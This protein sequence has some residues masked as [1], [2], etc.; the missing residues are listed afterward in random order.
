[1][2]LKKCAEDACMRS[3]RALPPALRF[4]HGDMS[5]QQAETACASQACVKCC[6]DQRSREGIVWVEPLIA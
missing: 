6:S 1:M 4:F 5:L 3:A 2:A